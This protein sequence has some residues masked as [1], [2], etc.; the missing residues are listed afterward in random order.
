MKKLESD[1]K[2]HAAEMGFKTAEL[3]VR[4]EEIHQKD[5]ASARAREIAVKDKTPSILAYVVIK[6][7]HWA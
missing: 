1:V 3:E 7:A 2:M 5:R 4:E 6:A